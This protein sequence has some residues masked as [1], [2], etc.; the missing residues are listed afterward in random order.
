LVD[1]EG[2]AR[3]RAADPDTVVVDVRRAGEWRSEHVEG[4]HNVPLHQLVEHLHH[5]PAGELWVHCQS[6]MRAGIGASLLA[7]AGY[8]V[9]LVNDDFANASAAGLPMTNE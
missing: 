3:Q 7:R 9:V 2:L 1:F 4:S 8:P 6:G 5:V